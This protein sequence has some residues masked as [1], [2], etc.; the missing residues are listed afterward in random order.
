M[1]KMQNFISQKML[2]LPIKIVSIYLLLTYFLFICS[3]MFPDVQNP[4]MLTVFVLSA[5]LALFLGYFWSAKSCPVHNICLGLPAAKEIYLA[6][7]VTVIGSLYLG[8]YGITTLRNYG[9]TNISSILNSV[10]NPG[11]AYAAK[12][13]VYEEQ[14]RYGSVS[15]VTQLLVL[16][17]VVYAIFVPVFIHYWKY[18]PT[19]LKALGTFSISFYILSFLFIG[20]QKAIGDIIILGSAGG[21]VS[22]AGRSSTNKTLQFRTKAIVGILCFCAFLGMAKIQA[23]RAEH[24]GLSTTMI[25]RDVR[26]N[27]L[28]PIV[29]EN[30]AAGIYHL[31]G[32]P[33]HGYFGLSK[34][35][36]TGFTFAYGAG[37]FPSFESYR[38]QY[39]GGADNRLLT[40]PHRTEVLTGWPAGMYWS[41]AFPW[42]ASDLTFPGTIVLL[43]LVGFLFAKVWINCLRYQDLISLGILG[44]M[45]IFFAFLPANNQVYQSRQGLWTTLA[46]AVFSV[47]WQRKTNRSAG[48]S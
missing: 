48:T 29:G 34:N 8:L 40:Y 16:T 37:L 6:K 17:A 1:P 32:Y 7:I 23:S 46:L 21:L 20:T 4:V 22:Y 30:F 9:G 10:Q 12:F 18:L 25:V 39:L 43:F 5:Y 26:N 28:T 27:F 45:F 33:S 3:N 14:L 44:Q 42:I 15:R 24:F 2:Y 38:Y 47:W 13:Q 35:F 36:D 19:Y 11:A 41:T 31:I